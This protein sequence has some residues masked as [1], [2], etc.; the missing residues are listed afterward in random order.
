[1]VLDSGEGQVTPAIRWLAV[2]I[3]MSL[4][5]CSSIKPEADIAAVSMG[6]TRRSSSRPHW[7]EVIAGLNKVQTARSPP[8][9]SLVSEPP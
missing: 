5:A 9:K 3:G 4:S 8:T 6:V 7:A 1:M 2:R